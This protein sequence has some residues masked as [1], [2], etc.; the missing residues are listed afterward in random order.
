MWLSLYLPNVNEVENIFMCLVAIHFS[1][2]V[3]CVQIFLSN[4]IELFFFLV[5]S[6]KSAIY[7]TYYRLIIY[8]KNI[9]SQS[10]NRLVIFFMSHFIEQELSFWWNPIYLFI[11]FMINAFVSSLSFFFLPIPKSQRFS[12]IVSFKWFILLVLSVRPMIHFK[13]SL[14]YVMKS[15]FSFFHMNIQLI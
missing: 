1:S 15:K 13:F 2:L 14:V 6:C 9:L 11:N 12:P 4:Y 5:F 8:I 7:K 3:N 10:G